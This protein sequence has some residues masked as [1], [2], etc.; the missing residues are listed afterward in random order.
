MTIL[1]GEKCT[2]ALWESQGEE[3]TADRM[4]DDGCF[5]RRRSK[6]RRLGAGATGLGDGEH[7]WLIREE[8]AEL[9]VVVVWGEGGFGLEP[10][11]EGG[12]VF[13]F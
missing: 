6:N 9:G 11:E 12:D 3:L 10:V 13:Y 7:G 8:G 4:S 2:T 1:N 5:L